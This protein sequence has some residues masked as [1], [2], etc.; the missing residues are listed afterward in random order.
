MSE[1]SEEDEDTCQ[2][3]RARSYIPRAASCAWSWVH[4]EREG[5]S[6][7]AYFEQQ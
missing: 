6:V 7:A 4:N 5:V 3:R 2:P 1:G